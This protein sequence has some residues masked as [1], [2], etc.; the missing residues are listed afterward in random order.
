MNFGY[1]K[2][3]AFTPLIKVAD[4]EFNAN[5][6]INGIESSY[7]IGVQGL[8]FPQLCVTGATCGDLFFSDILLDGA[9]QSLLKIA[10]STLDKQ[11]LVVVGLPLKVNGIIYNVA[12][13]INK[14]KIIAII[15]KSISNSYSDVINNNRYFSEYNSKFEEY[16]YI[17]NENDKVP[18][19]KNIILTDINN[20][21]F[22]IGIELGEELFSL[23]SYSTSYAL[24][25]AN[26]IV[27]LSSNCE[28]VGR[29]TLI[30]NAIINQSKKLCCSY[31][32]ANSGSGESTTDMVFAGGNIIAENGEI[33]AKKESFISGLTTNEIDLDYIEFERSKVFSSQ[34]KC[35]NNC[36]NILFDAYSNINSINRIYKKYP[37]IPNENAIE[38]RA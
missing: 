4:T 14:G 27:N 2:L 35:E 29:R 37:F 16:I 9:K 22:S 20:S 33:L 3:G 13:A 10:K 6:I 15:P 17:N 36:L 26:I 7:K 32:Y 23:N 19:G 24:N 25:G 11:I 1:V 31:V 5:Q 30:E 21:K 18:F 8:I 12:V 28:I 34:K 38:N